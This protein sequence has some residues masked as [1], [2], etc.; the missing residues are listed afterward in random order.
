[1]EKYLVKKMFL[2]VEK[3]HINEAK[4]VEFRELE[5]TRKQKDILEALGLISWW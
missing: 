3:P 5:R 2:E 1:M 4:S